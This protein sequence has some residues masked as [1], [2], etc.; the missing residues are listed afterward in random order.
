MLDTWELLSSRSSHS[1]YCLR[2]V[3]FAEVDNFLLC[4]S[5]NIDSVLEALYQK[6]KNAALKKNQGTLKE[7]THMCV[8]ITREEKLEFLYEGTDNHE[9]LVVLHI[10]FW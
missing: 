3:S 7:N 1:L 2:L 5:G 6:R 8:Y 9:Y 10:F 4:S